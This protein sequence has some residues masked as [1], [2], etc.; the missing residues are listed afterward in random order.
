MTLY[1]KRLVHQN[2]DYYISTTG[3]FKVIIGF[4]SCELFLFKRI[5]L[6]NTY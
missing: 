4:L 1:T 5:A 6:N 3:I 2:Q